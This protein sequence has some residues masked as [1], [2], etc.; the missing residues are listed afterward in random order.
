MTQAESPTYA[1]FL[2]DLFFDPE[3]GED[4]FLRNVR[5]SPNNTPYSSK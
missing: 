3:Y 5:L 1:D 2:L 4:I